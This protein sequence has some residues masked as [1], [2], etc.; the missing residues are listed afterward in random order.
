MHCQS[1]RDAALGQ[2]GV[3]HNSPD[4]P[5]GV[6]IT[7]RNSS[8]SSDHRADP[9]QAKVVVLIFKGKSKSRAGSRVRCLPLGAVFFCLSQTHALIACTASRPYKSDRC[10]QIRARENLHRIPLG[11]TSTQKTCRAGHARKH[12]HPLCPPY[13]S[14]HARGID[15]LMPLARWPG[16][17]R[18]GPVLESRS[19]RVFESKYTRSC[20]HARRSV[21]RVVPFPRHRR[22]AQ[23]R[24]AERRQ[25]LGRR[26]R[27]VYV[28]CVGKHT[29]NGC[30]NVPVGVVC[31]E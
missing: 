31:T 1:Q 28:A 7:R 22:G 27:V 25:C 3:A 15:A 17:A 5:A 8:S 18:P 11:Y 23:V 29:C 30:D 26:E 12:R 16:N 20:E 4:F 6:S 24:A 19:I 13:E 9:A 21:P 14:S 10:Y 2:F